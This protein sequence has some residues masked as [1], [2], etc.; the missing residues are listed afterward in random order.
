LKRLITRKEFALNYFDHGFIP[1]PL[2]WVKDNECACFM[3]HTEPKQIGKAPLVK[4]ANVTVTREMVEEWFT[5]YPEANIGLLLKESGLVI[6]DADS[7]EAVREFETVWADTSKI[8]SVTTGRGKHY[9]FKANHETSLYR[10]THLGKSGLIDIFSLGYIVAPPSVHQNGHKYVWSNP[11]KKIGLPNVPYWIERLLKEKSTENENAAKAEISITGEK[12]DIRLDELPLSNFAKSLIKYGECSPY[13]AQ[14]GYKSRSE[15]LFGMIV[16]C[17]E[18]GLTDDQIYSIFT[19]PRYVLSYRSTDENR[20]D[21]WLLKE[22]ERAKAKKN[23]RS[24][25]TTTPHFAFNS[26]QANEIKLKG[27]LN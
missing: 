17:Y 7:S 8:P 14:R 23:S 3:K 26:I 2:C 10:T 22:M 20:S 15:A 11:P 25:K 16:S 18:K 24:T 9:Y 6:V 1:I 4:Y 5:R 19:N 13:Y 27:Q 12:K 21:R